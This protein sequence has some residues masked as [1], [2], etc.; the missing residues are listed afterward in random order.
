MNSSI[1]AWSAA[2]LFSRGLIA[3]FSSGYEEHNLI[4]ILKGTD[5]PMKRKQMKKNRFYKEEFGA[6]K[7]RMRINLSPSNQVFLV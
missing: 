4:E 6:T 2:I 7:V 3:L 5:I 1:A